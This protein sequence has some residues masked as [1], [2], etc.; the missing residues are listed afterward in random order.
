MKDDVTGE[1]LVQRTDDSEEVVLKRLKLYEQQSKPV[2]DF[3][4]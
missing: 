4:K 1:P 3:Y 2:I